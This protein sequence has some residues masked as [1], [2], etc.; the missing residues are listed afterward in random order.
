MFFFSFHG[1]L[2]AVY[3]LKKGSTRKRLDYKHSAC[4]KVGDANSLLI[5]KDKQNNPTIF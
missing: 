2:N 3:Q 1:N 5:Q 4:S